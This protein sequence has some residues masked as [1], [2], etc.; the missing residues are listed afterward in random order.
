PEKEYAGENPK[1]YWIVWAA[2][3]TSPEG[4]YFSGCAAC[5]ILV[6]REDRRIKPGYKSMPEHVN[7]LDK[8]LKGK[9]ILTQMDDKSKQLL[10]DFLLTY[11]DYWDRSSDELKAQLEI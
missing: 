4:P 2:L 10:K 9:F 5:E 6:S 11:K 8:A 1:R 7:H 3:S